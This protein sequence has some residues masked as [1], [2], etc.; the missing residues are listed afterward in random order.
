M[1]WFPVTQANLLHLAPAFYIGVG[2]AEYVCQGERHCNGHNG[3]NPEA[4]EAGVHAFRVY[5]RG[6]AND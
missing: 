3:G 6:E 4:L 5:E 1:G 2:E